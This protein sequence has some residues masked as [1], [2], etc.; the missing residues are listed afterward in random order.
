L[1]T[2]SASTTLTAQQ[3]LAADRLPI[4]RRIRVAASCAIRVLRTG[5]T[6]Q[7]ESVEAMLA[8]H[9]TGMETGIAITTQALAEHGMI[10]PPVAA[11]LAPHL[12]LVSGGA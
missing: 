2:K 7:H 6:W 3:L 10:A 1:N 8:G 9:R 12:T 5:R 4:R 11:T